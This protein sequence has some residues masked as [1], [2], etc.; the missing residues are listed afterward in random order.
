MFDYK[1]F[2]RNMINQSNIKNYIASVINASDFYVR[3]T[4]SDDKPHASLVVITTMDDYMH[5]FF[6]TDRNPFKYKN[7]IDNEKIALLFDN[8]SSLCKNQAYISVLNAF[9]SA[10]EIE[11]TVSDEIYQ[12]HLLI[13]PALKSFHLSSDYTIFRFKVNAYK[14]VNRT[15]NINFWH[16]NT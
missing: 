10:R 9:S 12:N 3:A 6:A 4:V 8:R 13:N 7:L 2:I 16:I 1:K 5:L 15:D 14:T 11:I